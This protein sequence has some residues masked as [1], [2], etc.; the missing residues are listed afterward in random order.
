MA[1]DKKIDTALDK[2]IEEIATRITAAIPAA[3]ATIVAIEKKAEE[4]NK[5][6]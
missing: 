5:K 3:A 6:K 2:K 4:T 1:D